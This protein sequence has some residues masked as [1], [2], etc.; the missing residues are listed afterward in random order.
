M[1]RLSFVDAGVEFEDVRYS[2][3]EWPKHK[4]GRLHDS[5]ISFFLLLLSCNSLFFYLEKA[6]KRKTNSFGNFRP[7][8]YH[9]KFLR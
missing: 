3:E 8:V 4:A 6:I 9:Y 5:F 1:I 7:H 2:R